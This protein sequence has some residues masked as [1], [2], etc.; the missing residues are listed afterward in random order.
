MKHL[1]FSILIF[2]VL[3]GFSQVS[4]NITPN[5][6]T[7]CAGSEVRFVATLTGDTVNYVFY[8]KKNN[9]VSP[10]PDTL[11]SFNISAVSYPDTITCSAISKYDTVQSDTAFIHLR[12]NLTIDTLYRYNDLACPGTCKGQM[13]T[14]ISGGNPPYIYD[15]GGGFNQDSIVFGLCKGRYILK[16]VDSDNS[17]CVSRPYTIDVLRL[18]KVTFT[19]DPPDTIY[20]TKPYL[21]VSFP[22]SSR[23]VMTNWEWSFGDSTTVAN[24]NPLQHIYTK[25]GRFGVTLNYTDLN[26]CDTTILDTITVKTA[27]LKIASVFSPNH[28]DYNDFFVIQVEGDRTL[29]INEIY[30]STELIIVNRWG[31]KV[32]QA[33]PYKSKNRESGWDGDGVSDGVYFYVLKCHGLYEDD[34]YKGS[35]TILR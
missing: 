29:D 7:L 24:V 19:M 2:L 4:L 8:W 22:D 31:R 14:L 23:Q 17:H 33:S 5:N 21:N 12:P 1:L 20:L 3:P 18:P 9:V 11:G 32:Y 30:L 15:W 35:V 6:I 28:D 34:V 13:K 16:V 26:G 25:T 10:I 27:K